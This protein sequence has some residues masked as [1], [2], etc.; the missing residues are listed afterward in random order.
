M[1]GTQIRNHEKQ[2]NLPGQSEWGTPQ[3]RELGVAKAAPLPL[4]QHPSVSLMSWL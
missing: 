2:R 3:L 1:L 4:A